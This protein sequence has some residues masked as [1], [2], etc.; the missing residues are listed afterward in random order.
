MNFK[1]RNFLVAA[2]IAIALFGV[3]PA[4]SVAQDVFTQ[5]LQNLEGASGAPIS[6]SRNKQGYATHFGVDPSLNLVMPVNSATNDADL[7]ARAF[8]KQNAALLV[9]SG[10]ELSLKPQ[11]KTD[12]DQLGF[13]HSYLRQ[14]YRGI[15]VAGSYANVTMKSNGVTNVFS[16]LTPDFKDISLDATIAAKQATL[17]AQEI[18]LKLHGH[19]AVS[20]SIPEL[21]IFDRAIF[22]PSASS[23]PQLTWFIEA[24]GKAVRELIWINAH[25]GNL[26]KRVNQLTSAKNR[27]TYDAN[28]QENV[29]PGTLKRSENQAATG[30]I[31]VDNAH[32]YAGSTYDFYFS[33]FGRDSYDDA[34]S[35]IISSVRVC[36]SDFDE[37]CPDMLNAFWDGDQMAYGTGFS[38][39]E[40]VVAHELTHAVTDAT[41]DLIYQY[42]SGALN[43]SYSD[44]FGE[45]V[46]LTGTGSHEGPADRWVIGEEIPPPVGPFRNMMDPTLFNQPDKVDSPYYYC[47]IEDGGGVHV[48]SGVANHAYALMVDGG[49]FN[50]QTVR[51]IGLTRAS[52]IQYRTLT[53]KLGQS[54]T[55]A[56]NHIALQVSCGELIGSSEGITSRDCSNVQRALNSVE[57]DLS[58]CA[59][60]PVDLCPVGTTPNYLFQD[61]FEVITSGNWTYSNIEGLDHW[62]GAE[63]VPPVYSD[64]NPNNGVY[65]LRGQDLPDIGDS[66]VAMSSSIMLPAAAR[67]QFAH[68]FDTE[69]EFDGGVVEYSTDNGVAW[70]DADALFSDGMEYTHT[71][72]I[73][74]N[75]LGGRDVFNGSSYGYVATQLD[76]SSLSGQSVRFRFRMGTDDAVG[77]N[78]WYVDDV[79]IYTCENS[80][81]SSSKFQPLAPC[82][83]FDTRSSGNKI[84]AGMSK[85]FIV[86]GSDAEIQSQ[87][88]A[89]NCGVP[90]TAKA[91][92]INL[93]ST[94]AEDKGNLR[95]YPYN[96]SLPT[97][98][99]LNF[100]IDANMANATEIQI[101]QPT[102]L[103][104]INIYST[105]DSH[106]I[107]DVMG[108]F[109]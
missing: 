77:A 45:S 91:V 70:S 18:I 105:A 5:A 26:V 24:Q 13:S 4:I 60:P 59:Q 56:D 93:T 86:S 28:H 25:T 99:I 63:G 52:A 51:G 90:A 84:S 15:P 57:M 48:N 44:I 31:E 6:V 19:V 53:T 87:G 81:G 76:L 39:A 55:L 50:G 17:T 41:A 94:Q 40:D 10:E 8:L 64:S 82:R 69:I 102:C 58:P 101:C 109:E 47:G 9:K 103:F 85:P 30:D 20:F 74:T 106:V 83:V 71:L 97:S 89:G 37:D 100:N 38:A 75:P 11:R 72:P 29:L 21:Q 62:T 14:Y 46:E 3:T 96:S 67:M 43:E 33:H 54:S 88:G 22:K 34:G 95:V 65:S 49:N 107:G 78:P 36:G 23:R 7:R 104:D 32:D 2:T 12:T 35:T 66:T 16:R 68:D 108:Y 92:A 27:L 79:A 98:S 1:S 61:G 42:E 80:G 73:E